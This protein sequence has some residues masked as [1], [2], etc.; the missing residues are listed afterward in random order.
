MRVQYLRAEYKT[1]LQEPQQRSNQVKRIP[2]ILNNQ[3]MA[4]AIQRKQFKIVAATAGIYDLMTLFGLT[5]RKIDRD[6]RI[7]VAMIAVI[8]KMNNSHSGSQ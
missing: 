4:N 5:A 6:M 7:P 3:F 8:N 2:A 1:K